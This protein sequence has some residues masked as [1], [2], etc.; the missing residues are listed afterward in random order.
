MYDDSNEDWG[1]LGHLKILNKKL[2]EKVNYTV[3][4]LV[5]H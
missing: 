4:S 3:T 5:R 1:V 2:C